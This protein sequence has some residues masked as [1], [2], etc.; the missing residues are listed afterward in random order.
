[1]VLQ[2]LAGVTEVARRVT[3]VERRAAE[4]VG[5]GQEAERGTRKG[6]RGVEKACRARVLESD[7]K[8][9]SSTRKVLVARA[10]GKR[11]D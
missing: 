1:M 4:V 6:Q 3:E 2:E 8:E 7:G 10:K 9:T 11:V 5:A